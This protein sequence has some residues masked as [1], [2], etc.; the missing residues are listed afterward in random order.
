[1]KMLLEPGLSAIP[2]PW[3]HCGI[4]TASQSSTNVFLLP[5]LIDDTPKNKSPRKC[6]WSQGF[7]PV[8]FPGATASQSSTHVFLLPAL[9]G[10]IPKTQVPERQRLK[11]NRHGGIT[12]GYTFY[13][14]RYQ[15]LTGWIL[16]F[17]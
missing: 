12:H 6:F 10:D 3:G 2:L 5:A 16:S 17:A 4:P 14:R 8:L 15:V 13:Q 1:M 7:W 11:M 9:K